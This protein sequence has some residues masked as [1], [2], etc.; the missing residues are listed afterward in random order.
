MS[1]FS[2]GPASLAKSDQRNPCETKIVSGSSVFLKDGERP[3]EDFGGVNVGVIVGVAVRVG[4]DVGVAV[5]VVVG[6]AVGVLVG[7]LKGEYAPM[8]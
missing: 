3:L 4:D 7:G 6:D 8:Q 1:A 5:G 2:P